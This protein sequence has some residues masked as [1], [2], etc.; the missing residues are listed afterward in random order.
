MRLSDL[1]REAGFLR[2]DRGALF[3]LALA[4]VLSVLSVAFGLAE[5]RDQR[6]T[7]AVLKV[8]DAADRADAIARQSDWG[9]AA[10][11]AFHL[12]YDPPSALAF[13]AL[14]QRD[15]AAWKHRIRMLA[16][17][18]QIYEADT[19]NPDFAL[20]GRFDFAFVAAYLAPLLLILLLYDMR[21]GER[22]AGRHDLLVTTAGQA[23]RLWLPRAL[24]RYIALSGC[25]LLPLIVGAMIETVPIGA[26]AMACLVVIGSLFI[27]WLAVEL[28]SRIGASTS[29]LLTFMIGLW[30]TL[31]VVVPALAKNVIEARYPVPDG[32]EI[33]M[34]QREAVNDAWDLPKEAT[35][36]PFLAQYPEWRE[37]GSIAR[38]F[39]WKW[40][41][42]FQQV[43][44]QQAEPLVRQYRD[45]RIARDRA[46]GTASLLSPASFVER[47]L[48]HLAY[49]D[50]S[51]VLSYE[52]AI[53]DFHARLRQFHYQLLFRDPPYN[54]ESLDQLPE[55]KPAG[56]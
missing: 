40:Y 13:A 48:E 15:N 2:R 33:M 35:M 23:R 9:G 41:Y 29:V 12:T 39:E 6:A 45:G 31:C 50:V 28:I 54:P 26:V 47:R 55:F 51:A 19:Q 49:T 7:I 43:G 37:R 30:L 42:A 10:Y 34:L 38:P 24:L 25:I 14:G 27:W 1:S 20:V 46:A 18:G 16:L 11:H 21:S 8:E 44:D 56:P 3:W 52:A 53:R 5:V 4:L 17:E 22:A 36:E 32:G